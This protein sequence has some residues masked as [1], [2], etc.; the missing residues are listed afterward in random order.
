M[1]GKNLLSSKQYC[2]IHGR[3]TATQLLSYLDKY[4]D[5][6]VSGIVVDAIHFDFNKAFDNVPHE[7]LLVKLESHGI[8]SNV[9][10]WIKAFLRSGCQIVNLRGWNQIQQLPWMDSPKVVSPDLYFLS[11][12]CEVVKCGTYLFADRQ[13]TTKEDALQLQS[14]INSLQQLSE[15]KNTQKNV[16][17]WHWENFITLPTLRS[18]PFHQQ[19]LE[20]VFEQK[21][22]GVILHAELKF[23][24]HLP[25][26]VKKANAIAG[27]IRRTFLYL[28][29]TLL[30]KLFTTFVRPILN[31]DKWYGHNIWKN[32][33]PFWKMCNT[34]QQN[35]WIVFI[36]WATHKG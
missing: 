27:L 26:K 7:R 9:L 6:I 22:L 3:S 36:T 21:D 11:Y 13:I 18:T 14:D 17:S 16:M 34:E 20:H 35:W 25:V 23:D 15:K 32:I 2:F 28:D 4:I 24:E 1:R 12:S 8:N 30:K 10:K 31:M 29:G 5:T 19:E 33:W